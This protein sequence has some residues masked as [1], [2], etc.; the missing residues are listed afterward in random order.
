MGFKIN[1]YD[2]CVAKN[3][4]NGHQMTI[5]WHV[6]DLKV[7]HKDDNSV[8]VLAEKLA[9]L[10]VPKN[11]IYRRKVHGYLGM[12]INWASVPVTMIVS[13]IKYMHKVI[14]ELPEVLRGTK[15]SPDGYHL[16]IVR[17]DGKRNSIQEKQARKFHRTVAQLLSLCKRDRR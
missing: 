7:S 3:M 11:T 15:A 14:E 5:C 10:Y 12:D 17:E 13:M 4:V 9:E 2:P 1:P 6:D 8:T 16:F